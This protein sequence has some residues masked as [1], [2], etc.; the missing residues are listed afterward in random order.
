MRTLDDHHDGHELNESLTIYT[1]EP[2]A[3]GAAHA[4]T[5]NIGEQRV[6]H[7]QFQKGPRNVEGS[8][9]G[10]TEAV[11][12]AI[13]IDRLRGFQSGPYGCRENAIQLT[14]LE[15]ALMW[16]EKRADDRAKRGVL[17]TNAR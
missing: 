12:L 17:G 6:A 16:T 10:A 11:L 7:V 13:L 2:D 14:H 9:P 15:E 4:Y 5:V 1:D 3:S 8:T